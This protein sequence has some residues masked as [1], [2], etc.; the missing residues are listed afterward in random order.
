M[1]ESKNKHLTEL[2]ELL[3][4]HTFEEQEGNRIAKLLNKID[5]AFIAADFK[6]NRTLS[7][8]K[9]IT[10]VLNKTIQDLEEKSV[11]LELQKKLLEEQSRFKEQLFANVSHEL[12]TPLNG[13]LGMSYLL[14]ETPLETTQKSYVDVIKSSADNLLVIINDLLNLSKI[15]AGQIK[16]NLEPFST[17]KFYSDLHGLLNIKAQEK[18]LSLNFYVSPNIPKYLLGDR[19]RLYQVLLNLLNNAIKFT[20][21][22]SVTLSTSIESFENDGVK[23]KFEII[24]TGIGIPFEKLN[25]IFDSFTQ[26]HN[27]QDFVYEGT[28]LG[29]NIVKKLLD[30]MKG[31]IEVNSEINVGT[32]F[33]VKIP[34]QIPS[35]SLIHQYHEQQTR[36]S[37]PQSWITKKILYIEDNK[38]NLLYAQNMFANWNIQ[39]D[40]AED[41]KEAQ[42]MLSTKRYDCILSD[43]KLPDGNGLDFIKQLREHIGGINQHT[44]VIVLT[45]GANEKGEN[46]SKKLN[47]ISYI[48]KPFPPAT[49]IKSLNLVFATN[50]S[51]ANLNAHQQLSGGAIQSTVNHQNYLTHLR[52]LMNNNRENMAEMINIFLNQLPETLKGLETGIQLADWEKVHFEAHKIKSSIMVIGLT[53]LESL[54]MKINQYSKKRENLYQIPALYNSFKKQALIEVQELN[55]AKEDLLNHA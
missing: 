12:R 4:S 9:I 38:A 55:K 14:E 16:I 1:T 25:T 7:D 36:L 30:L 53:K 54:I 2:I 41:L 3:Q 11:A 52:K 33:S 39:I 22:G 6:V 8:K 44:P 23:L 45:A 27:S 18:C 10:N 47:I 48:G 31:D 5:R 26:V 34:F 13:I 51:R 42:Q 43:V 19:T 40:I 24:D 28:G 46:M 17:E 21:Y 50:M 15:N 29:L 20:H 37:I 35:D 49:I 32:T